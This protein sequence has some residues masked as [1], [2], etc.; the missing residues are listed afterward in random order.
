M[1][2]RKLQLGG[3]IGLLQDGDIITIDAEAGTLD[4]VN[5]TE[6]EFARAP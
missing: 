1:S 4:C 3:P 2:G 5:V 6:A